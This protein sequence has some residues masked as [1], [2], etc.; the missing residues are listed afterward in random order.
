MFMSVER[1]PHRLTPSQVDVLASVIGDHMASIPQA[2]SINHEIGI[3]PA[4]GLISKTQKHIMKLMGG[5]ANEHV[6]LMLTDDE[7]EALKRMS[8]P[9]DIHKELFG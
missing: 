6:V 7:L 9:H 2:Q 3:A 8:L 1:Y 5:T 4:R